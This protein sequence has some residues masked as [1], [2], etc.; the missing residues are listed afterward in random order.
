MNL[1]LSSSKGTKRSILFN[2]AQPSMHLST[3]TL[4]YWIRS[5]FWNTAS[6]NTQDSVHLFQNKNH[7]YPHIHLV[8]T[9]C[10]LWESITA[11]FFWVGETLSSVIIYVLYLLNKNL[12]PSLQL[13][14]PFSLLSHIYSYRQT[15]HQKS[16]AIH[17]LGTAV[18]L[19]IHLSPLDGRT[20]WHELPY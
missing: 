17:S 20:I 12:V 14:M 2:W 13:C 10:R 8:Q 11:P 3:L 5:R 6:E 9:N 19:G 4:D 18:E 15:I 1:F 7:A 16:I